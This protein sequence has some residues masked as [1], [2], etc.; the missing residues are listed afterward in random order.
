MSPSPSGAASGNLELNTCKPLIAYDL[1]QSVRLL[2]DA[3]TSFEDIAC[4]ASRP[5]AS[6]SSE[7]LGAS[8]MLVTALVP[9]IGYDKAAE[10][11]RLAHR[12]GST[13]NRR[14]GKLGFV[15]EEDFDRWVHPARMTLPVRRRNFFRYRRSNRV[16]SNPNRRR[17]VV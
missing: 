17:E 10:I 1:L 3:M 6:A 15:S 14:A 11:A 16:G 5:T 4:A 8:L 2:A 9:H 13:L 7:A 12:E